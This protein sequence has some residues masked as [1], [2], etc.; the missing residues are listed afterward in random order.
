MEHTS[1]CRPNF[2]MDQILR[3]LVY[4]GLEL[5]VQQI[6]SAHKYCKHYK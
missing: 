1:E 4:M 3:G 2:V 6:Y 5:L